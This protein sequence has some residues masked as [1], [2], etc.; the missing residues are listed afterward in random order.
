VAVY[1]ARLELK[2]FDSLTAI[3]IN[4]ISVAGNLCEGDIFS[5]G[6]NTDAPGNWLFGSGVQIID[7]QSDA[8]TQRLIG[9]TFSVSIPN[10]IPQQ[11]FTIR[12]SDYGYCQET[13]ED[14]LFVFQDDNP[15]FSYVSS[16][17]GNGRYCADELLKGPMENT[18]LGGRFEVNS[19]TN[20]T[21]LWMGI[22]PAGIISIDS[23]LLPTDSIGG[24][25][26]SYK[27]SIRYIT[28]SVCLDTVEKSLIV[29]PKVTRPNIVLNPATLEIC[30]GDTL[31]LDLATSNYYQ[32]FHLRQGFAI[33]T[34]VRSPFGARDFQDSDSVTF[35]YYNEA[36][37]FGESTVGLT[38]HPIPLMGSLNDE[39]S[40]L[41][42]EPLTLGLTS[43]LPGTEYFWDVTLNS[44]RLDSN[45]LRYPAAMGNFEIISQLVLE[46]IAGDLGIQFVPIA[47]GCYGDTVKTSIKVLPTVDKL[48]IP[49]VITPNADGFNDDW[50]IQWTNGDIEPNYWLYLYNT[51][52]G[53]IAQFNLN[54][55]VVTWQPDGVPDGTYRWIILAQD[56]EIWR[57]GGLAIR[58][59][60]TPQSK[61]Q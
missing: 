5:F 57:K 43:T 46:Y 47:N 59:K 61:A 44:V 27:L 20:L 38:V 50:V 18:P 32:I 34:I 25:L 56:K 11:K 1:R 21:N 42:K 14:S 4:P 60:T 37:C 48:F 24:G 33:D 45:R 3:E 28:D 2:A 35:R 52:G 30:D 10:S 15:D 17:L 13:A 26:S 12:L 22:S 58:R 19:D 23:S 29:F 51:N 53:L 41:N 40:I 54:Q 8:A 36:G 9:G 55:P 39:Y 16:V 7:T 31:S 49:G 6:T